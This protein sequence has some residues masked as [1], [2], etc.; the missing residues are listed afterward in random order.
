MNGFK[1]LKRLGLTRFGLLMKIQCRNKIVMKMSMVLNFTSLLKYQNISMISLINT[2]H[3][4]LIIIINSGFVYIDVLSNDPP[5]PFSIIRNY[6]N[7]NQSLK[8]KK[9]RNEL[10]I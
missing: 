5:Y 6:I 2:R 10:Y 7:T 4:F 9:D 1:N 8:N 3:S